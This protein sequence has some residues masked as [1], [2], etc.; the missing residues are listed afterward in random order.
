MQAIQQGYR[1]LSLVFALNLDHIVI[2]LAI[3]VGLIGGAML[4]TA[5]LDFQPQDL[6]RVH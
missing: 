4:G 6:P 5:I 2:P 1:G 3:L